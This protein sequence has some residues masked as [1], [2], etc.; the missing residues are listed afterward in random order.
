MTLLRDLAVSHLK[1]RLQ[2]IHR[3]L[4]AAVLAQI[5]RASRLARA[6]LTPLCITEDEALHLLDDAERFVL[7]VLPAG[8]QLTDAAPDAGAETALRAGRRDAGVLLPLAR[9]F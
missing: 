4:R 3:V 2:G 1:L 8:W 7:D 9:A 5:D 6:D